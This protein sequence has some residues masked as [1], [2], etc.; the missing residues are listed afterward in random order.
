MCLVY[1]HVGTI[2]VIY[3]CCRHF[4]HTT[5]VFSPENIVF[6]KSGLF[7]VTNQKLPKILYNL[8]Y[9]FKT[10]NLWSTKVWSQLCRLMYSLLWWMTDLVSLGG[11]NVEQTFHLTEERVSGSTES[12]RTTPVND[13]L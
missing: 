10:D 11:V 4:F 3:Y 8:R 1:K 2:E 13:A 12:L 9:H 5:N 6:C 7:T